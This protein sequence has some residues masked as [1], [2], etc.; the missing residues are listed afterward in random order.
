MERDGGIESLLEAA[1]APAD[2]VGLIAVPTESEIE[3]RDLKGE[4]LELHCESVLPKSQV[5]LGQAGELT[6]NVRVEE[7][8]A[9]AVD[10]VHE[11]GE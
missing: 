2:A 8:P 1:E 10:L 11:G 9:A 5:E 7:D 6:E 4:H 3:G